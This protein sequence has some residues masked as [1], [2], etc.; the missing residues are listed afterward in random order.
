LT[1]SVR[2]SVPG[3]GLTQPSS[4]IALVRSSVVES[5]TV[6]TAFVPLNE[7]ALPNLPAL[8]PAQVAFAIV[9]V[10]PLPD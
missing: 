1:T 10:L 7:S 2:K 8:A 3:F 6:T 5:A 9:P 4:V